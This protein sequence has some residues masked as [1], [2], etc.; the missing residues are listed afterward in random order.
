MKKIRVIAFALIAVCLSI[1]LMLAACDDGAGPGSGSGAGSG[2][3]SG[4]SGS[5]EK[6]LSSIEIK[7]QPNKVEYYVGEE[8]DL[9]GATIT[10][11]YSDGGS[12]DKAITV[13]MISGYDK[14]CAGTQTLTVIYSEGVLKRAQL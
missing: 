1:V 3:G 4:S 8:L 7:S 11:R 5:I 12:T 6:I 10:V 2:S 14:T 9:T 13:A